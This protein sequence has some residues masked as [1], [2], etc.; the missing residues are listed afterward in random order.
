MQ[1]ATTRFGNRVKEYNLY[2]PGYPGELITFLQV[3]NLLDKNSVV[4]DIGAGTGKLTSMLLPE[5]KQVHAIEPNE[6][7]LAVCKHNLSTHA[8]L[9]C[10]DATAE[11]TT[12]P[13]H[14]IDLIVAA[15]A[16]HWFDKQATH[17]EF[18]R[19]GKPKCKVVLVWNERISGDDFMDAYD[20]L[21]VKYAIDYKKVDHRNT[22][23]DTIAD[24]FAPNQMQFAYL[25]NEQELDITALV[26]R[27]LSCSYMPT[28]DDEKWPE[29]H[30]A[31]KKLFQQY[32]QNEYV[33]LRYITKIFYGTIN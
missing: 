18:E 8:N 23:P 22:T 6:P 27:T 4:A 5:V 17:K 21:L 7:M 28:A 10:I 3:Q 12:L 24:F 2:R 30:N 16:F 11:K 19:I 13:D 1:D 14:S 31:L 29:T 32:S 20:A 25:P 15:Q 9:H 26:G 33:S